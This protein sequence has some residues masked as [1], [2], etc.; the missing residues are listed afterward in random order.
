MQA[1][2]HD[3]A[4]KQR[5]DGQVEIGHCRSSDSI[6]GE[7]R[8]AAACDITLSP[9]LWVKVRVWTNG[10]DRVQPGFAT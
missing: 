7:W 8:G 1:G 9:D 3:V 6:F 10:M 2:L 5:P 4:L